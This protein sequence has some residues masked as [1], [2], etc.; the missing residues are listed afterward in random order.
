MSNSAHL[1]AS[2]PPPQNGHGA[3]SPDAT[4]TRSRRPATSHSSLSLSPLSPLS[5]PPPELDLDGQPPKLTAAQK[6]KGRASDLSSSG[7]PFKG[8]TAKRP[9]QQ[10]A[11]VARARRST[12]GVGSGGIGGSAERKEIEE[13]VWECRD[14]LG[15]SW[16]S[17]V[18]AL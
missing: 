12:M 16:P 6:G 9:E 7:A 8:K 11:R 18:V 17:S 3:A 13:L 5:S 4:L 2:D 14:R 15:E 1:L 10:P